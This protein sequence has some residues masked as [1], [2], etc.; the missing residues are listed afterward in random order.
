MVH[1]KAI[2]VNLKCI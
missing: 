1:T 2:E